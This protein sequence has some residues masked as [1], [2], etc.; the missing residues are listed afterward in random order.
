MLKKFYN[1][2]QKTWQ[3]FR[4]HADSQDYLTVN[5]SGIKSKQLLDL[6]GRQSVCLYGPEPSDIQS[7]RKKGPGAV[8]TRT[9]T[10]VYYE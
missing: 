1:L 6:N 2:S 4:P 3:I 8:L 9:R 7:P 10:T 5:S